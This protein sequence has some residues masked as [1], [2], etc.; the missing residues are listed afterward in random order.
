MSKGLTV[1]ELID[2]A[3]GDLKEEILALIRRGY[4][5]EMAVLCVANA[6]R[7]EAEG[8]GYAKRSQGGGK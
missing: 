3:A 1:S 4:V 7:D 5:L 6:R 8:R 2:E